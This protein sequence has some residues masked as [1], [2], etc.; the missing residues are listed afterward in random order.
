M[1]QRMLGN[2]AVSELGFGTMS[3]AS[4]YGQ[5]PDRAESIR[6]IR[7]AH[8]LG[9]TFFDTAEVYGPWTNEELV[10]EALKP[11]R[12]KVV[13]ATKFGFDVDPKTGARGAGL[14]S[15]PDHIKSV[16]DAMLA[17]LGMDCIDLLY[18]H[19]VDPQVPMEDVAGAVKD[20][21]AAG[22][23]KHFGLSE[24]GAASIR[25]AHA[26]QPVTAIQS[27]YSLWTR[28]PE[29]EV[30]PLCEELGIGFV[31]W[32]PLGAGYLTGK[33]DA[34]TPIDSGDFRAA[35]PR[36]T[37]EARMSN[38][39]LVELLKQIANAKGATPAQIALAWLLARK[40]F[41]VPIFGTRRLDRVEENLGAAEIALSAGDLAG[42]EAAVARIDIQGA[43]L[44]EAVLK[45]SYL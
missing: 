2:L 29:P 6:V 4:T 27:E 16:V 32:S 44:P 12:D 8:D 11:I 15:R 9:V 37:E 45:Y 3:F 39:A 43:R 7:G 40:P 25:R 20:L 34:T 41:I 18:Q 24:A 21:I 13:V 42:I 19:R 10:G 33:I 14:N 5:A 23:V 28:D 38:Q 30:L 26:V 36:F 22:K 17:R 35:S 31:P 1:K